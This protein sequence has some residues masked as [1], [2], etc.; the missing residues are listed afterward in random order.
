MRQICDFALTT[1]FDSDLVHCAAPVLTTSIP[2]IEQKTSFLDKSLSV[3]KC[4]MDCSGHY[5]S[6]ANIND[7]RLL[8][9][10]QPP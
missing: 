3:G 9:Q 10:Q 6:V 7:I 5:P 2:C 8:L 1:T 4:V